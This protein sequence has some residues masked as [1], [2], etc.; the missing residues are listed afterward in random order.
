MQV[1][2]ESKHS[3]FNDELREYVHEKVNK[4]ETYYNKIISAEVFM[5]DN[6]GNHEVEIKLNVPEDTLFVREVGV[7]FPAAVDLAVGTMKNTLVRYKGRTLHR[8]EYRPTDNI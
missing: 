5:H 3:E 6:N 4:L 7:S 8:G 1:T 2:I